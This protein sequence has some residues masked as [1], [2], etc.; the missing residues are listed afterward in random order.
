MQNQIVRGVIFEMT[1]VSNSAT[2]RVV[3]L[4]HVMLV[5]CD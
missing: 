3:C 5:Y 2:L 4:V 1:T